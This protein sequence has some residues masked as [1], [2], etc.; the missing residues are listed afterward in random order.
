MPD[1][2]TQPIGPIGG[3]EIGKGGSSRVKSYETQNDG[4]ELPPEDR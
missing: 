2:V 3:K 4:R 1:Y